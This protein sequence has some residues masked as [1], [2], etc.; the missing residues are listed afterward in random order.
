MK[1]KSVYKSCF[2]AKTDIWGNLLDKKFLKV[3]WAKILKI[4]A[5]KKKKRYQKFCK[6][7]NLLKPIMRSNHIY[8]YP[9]WFFKN[10]L[11]NKTCIRRFYGDIN[12]KIFKNL[13]FNK[14]PKSL[15]Q[16][17]ESRL[18]INLYRLG[19]FKSIFKSQQAIL[20]GKVF[21]NKKLVT[22]DH[23]L[24]KPGDLVEFCPKFRTSVQKDILI[25]R[26]CMFYSN[27]LK[28]KPTPW[29][30]HTDYSSLSFIVSG[31]VNLL[32]FYPFKIEFDEV[33]NSSKYLY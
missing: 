23:F 28:L 29:Y 2:W 14:T 3:K 17:L 9:Y 8:K 20:H 12:S 31:K 25:R 19:F 13:C 6:N 18:D 33:L 21:V 26:S 30:I 11:L 5:N 24:L 1:F 7:H 32:L 10:S 22:F 16:L 15:I 27:R 4:L